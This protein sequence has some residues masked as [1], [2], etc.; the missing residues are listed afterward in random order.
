MYIFFADDSKRHKP[1]LPDMGALIGIGGAFVDASKLQS[2]NQKIDKV[3]INYGFPKG[4]PFKWSPG[5]ELWMYSN[6]KL[7]KRRDFFFE[8]LSEAETHDVGAIVVTEDTTRNTATNALTHQMD[9]IKLF[10]ERVD[11]KLSRTRNEGILVIDRPSGDRSDEDKFMYE[12]LETMRQGTEYAKLDRII[13]SACTSSRLT[14]MLQLADLVTSCSLAAVSGE[15]QYAPPVFER[16]KKLLCRESGRMGGVGFKMHPDYCYA[17]LYH[18]LLE[19]S[20]FFKHNMGIP[21]PIQSRPYLVN[22]F[23]IIDEVAEKAT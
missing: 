11:W 12:C 3:C 4:E 22:P 23:I 15:K 7:E 6:L 16:I 17:N 19:D 9:A 1:S 8:V 21:L 18:W 14:R 2:L 20:H 10:L 5:R 13:V